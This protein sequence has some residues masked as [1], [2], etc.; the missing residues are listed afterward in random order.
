MFNW[1]ILIKR[2]VDL[3]TA[4]IFPCLTSPQGGLPLFYTR[5]FLFVKNVWATISL[6]FS[7]YPLLRYQHSAYEYIESGPPLIFVSVKFYSA[8]ILL[9]IWVHLL[10]PQDI[11]KT[12]PQGQQILL[13]NCLTLSLSSPSQEGYLNRK[14]EVR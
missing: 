12:I 6:F 14:N 10:I 13:V 5:C 1:S 2:L 11:F 8:Q 9:A 3:I 4:G 7:L